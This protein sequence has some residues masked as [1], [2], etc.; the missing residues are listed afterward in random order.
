M[1]FLL[2]LYT[3][4]LDEN[5]STNDQPGG[6]YPGS[7]AF[8]AGYAEL[9]LRLLC[10]LLTWFAVMLLHIINSYEDA[11]QTTPPSHYPIAEALRMRHLKH[12]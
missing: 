4:H 11:T 12:S 1:L 9:S 5:G 2:L 8:E 10:N 6:R 7:P 3:Q